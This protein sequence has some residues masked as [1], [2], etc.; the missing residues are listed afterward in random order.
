MTDPNSPEMDPRQTA[1]DRL[2]RRSMAAPVPALPPNFD[3]R[4]AR[5]VQ[6]AAQPLD[7]P[8]RM[9]LTA[10]ALVSAAVSVL[11]MRGQGLD[12]KLTGAA[13]LASLALVPALG[14]V[15]RQRT[16]SGE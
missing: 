9:F 3:Q 2:L 16:Q 8:A 4:V 5:E 1:M 15:H 14:S 6:R 7:R 13:L 10:Y 12:W 11:I